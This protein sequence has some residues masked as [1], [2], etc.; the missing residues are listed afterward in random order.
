MTEATHQKTER[1]AVPGRTTGPV[2]E[3][4]ALGNFL[5]AESLK[6]CGGSAP[7]KP[8][9]AANSKPRAA[10][11]RSCGALFVCMSEPMAAL[12]NVRTGTELSL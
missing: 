3:A 5:A 2:C 9:S 4:C 11:F 10:G 8:Q 12:A 1:L 6:A 7:D